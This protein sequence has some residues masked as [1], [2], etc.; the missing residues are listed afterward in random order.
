MNSCTVAANS[1]KIMPSR[2]MKNGGNCAISCEILEDRQDNIV[3]VPKK[4]RNKLK[5]SFEDMKQSSL[6]VSAK[7]WRSG[8]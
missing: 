7:E 6:V 8:S 4:F 3:E 1:L 2:I 5:M